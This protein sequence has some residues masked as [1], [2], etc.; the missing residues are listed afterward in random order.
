MGRKVGDAVLD[1][2]D[3]EGSGNYAQREQ[4][5]AA[6]MAMRMKAADA[7][8]VAEPSFEPGETTLQ[9]QVVGKVRFK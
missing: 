8:E 7:V 2:V 6:P 9:M 4:A 5:Y 1:T 3:F